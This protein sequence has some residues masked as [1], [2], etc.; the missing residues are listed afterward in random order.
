MKLKSLLAFGVLV[1]V[2]LFSVCQTASAATLADLYGTYQLTAA[3]STNNGQNGLTPSSVVTIRQSQQIEGGVEISNLFGQ[4]AWN[5]KFDE[6]TQTITFQYSVAAM[7]GTGMMVIGKE[8]D[9]TLD[10]SANGIVTLTVNTDGSITFTDHIGVAAYSYPSD[11][12]LIETID[13]GTLQPGEYGQELLSDDELV[14]SYVFTPTATPVLADE[15]QYGDELAK[16]NANQFMLV[17]TKDAAAGERHFL[18][19]G[20]FGTTWSVPAVYTDQGKLV[21]DTNVQNWYGNDEATANNP[22]RILVDEDASYILST[23]GTGLE[24][25]VEKGK[26]STS[27][28]MIALYSQ[29]TGGGAGVGLIQLMGGGETTMYMPMTPP[30]WTVETVFTG[31]SDVK[32]VTDAEADV[33]TLDGKFV[34]KRANVKQ[35]GLKHG[36]YVVRTAEGTKKIAL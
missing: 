34:A 31:I 7:S 15:T 1:L 24:F 18:V 11:L 3:G 35:L 30:N 6:T 21:F 28:G 12:L 5:G 22:Y 19:G 32:A 36:I 20:F 16:F 14:G 13:G 2:T 33:L 9:G 17:V 23:M 26:L 27:T 29:P 25:T 4:Y 8:V 10:T